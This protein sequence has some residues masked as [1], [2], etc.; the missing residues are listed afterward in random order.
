[1][2]SV[3]FSRVVRLAI[4]LVVVGGCSRGSQ[5]G[6]APKRSTAVNTQ[7]LPELGDYLPP[8]DNDRLELA[9]PEGWHVPSASSKYVVRVQK[10]DKDTYPSVTVTAEDYG[11]KGV[12]NVSQENVKEFAAQV[13]DAV[14]KDKSAV[15]PRKIGDFV[16]VAYAKRA[17]I[18]QPVTRILDVLYLETVV[19]GRKYRFELRSEEGSLDKDRPY[20]Y[21][22]VN[23]TRFLEAASE[24]RQE[25]SPEAKAEPKEKPTKDEG[26][27]KPDQPKPKPG[28]EEKPKQQAEEEAA[29][30]T[31]EEAKQQAKEESGEDDGVK[32][33]LDKLDE[34]I[35]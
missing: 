9:P 3:L 2:R 27:D 19:A 12:Q 6:S 13:A 29:E 11:G 33:D 18:R 26:P 35:K 24:P 7:K 5:R 31:K 8:L 25:A 23:G 20:L 1:M 21:A 32:L 10:S 16:G 34:L 4:L 17:K 14:N 30:G 15:Q 22:V 28:L